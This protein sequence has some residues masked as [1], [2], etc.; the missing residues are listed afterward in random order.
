[1]TA[2]EAVEAHIR[3]IEQVNQKLNA[4]VVK[5]YGAARA[6]ARDIDARRACGAS[7]PPLARLPINFARAAR[8]CGIA[9]ASLTN[10]EPK[11]RGYPWPELRLRQPDRLR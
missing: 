4:V 9:Q 8:R 10:A 6:K 11:I 5:H 2:L 7:R 3:R 1:M